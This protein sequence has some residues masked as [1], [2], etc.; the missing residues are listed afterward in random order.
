MDPLVDVLDVE[1]PAVLMV[2]SSLA[3]ENHT[4]TIGQE[5]ESP[6]AATPYLLSR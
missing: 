5:Y 2:D 4:N 1:V 3:L 6:G